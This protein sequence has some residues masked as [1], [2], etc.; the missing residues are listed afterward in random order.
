MTIEPALTQDAENVAIDWQIVK[1]S[2]SM[3]EIELN[4]L[5]PLYISFEKEPDILV[6]DFADEDLFI[7]EQGI[8]I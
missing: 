8:R 2:G 1:Y 7:T 5:T 4:F 3:I 6:V